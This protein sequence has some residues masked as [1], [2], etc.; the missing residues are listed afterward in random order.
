MVATYENLVQLGEESCRRFAERPLLAEKRDGQWVWT[1]YREFQDLV[2]AFRAGLAGLGV[3]P[4]DRVAIVSRNSLAWAVAAYATYGLQ[5]TFV[6]MYEAQLPDEWRFILAD[7]GAT[8]VLGSNEHVVAALDEMRPTLPDLRHV[9]SVH[10]P[11]D[12]PRSFASLLEYGRAHPTPSRT[13][14]ADSIAGFIYTSGTTGKPKGAMLSHR[15]LASNVAAALEAFPIEADDRTVSFLPWAHVYGQVVELHILVAAGASTAINTGLDQLVEELGEIHPTVLVA[16]PRIFNRIH[17]SVRAQIAERAPAIQHL[18]HAGIHAALRQARGE[19]LSV[20]ARTNR[21][22]ADHLIFSKIRRKFGGNLRYAISASA[23]LSREVA[24]FIDALG[25]PVYEGYGLTETSPVVSTNRPGSRRMGSVGLPIP[26]VTLRID[27]AASPEPGEGEIIVYGPNVMAGYHNRPDETARALTDDGGLRTGDLGHFD[28]D[29]YLHIT[30]R[31][32]EQYKLENG[33]Y[34][35]PT[36]LEEELALSPYIANVMLY[37][38]GH[39][40]NVALIVLDLPRVKAWAEEHH[41]E[42][43]DD[44]TQNPWV[45][46]LISAEID[47]ASHEFRGYEKPRAFALVTDDFT[48]D[49]DMLTP[50]LKLKRR[51]V[52]GRYGAML[53]GLYGTPTAEPR[54]PAPAPTPEIR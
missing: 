32:K 54:P 16:V 37:G 53:E 24:E 7:S 25:I 20:K 43:G 4:G 26:G 45:R 51:N 23:T 13:P 15:N 38:S 6:P 34:V 1:S 3:E 36:P 49:S 47:T 17:D 22:L 8:V 2:D 50:T 42:L 33:K 46:D 44:P 11:T 5:A 9:V 27:D 18:F 48:V 40:Y 14:A 31:I 52:V 39:A 28:D 21:W 29:G 12:D 35:M 30:G 19:T 10:G 41:I